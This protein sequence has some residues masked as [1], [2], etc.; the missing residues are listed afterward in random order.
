MLQRLSVGLAVAFLLAA[1]AFG[2]VLAIEAPLQPEPIGGMTKI[3][4]METTC[5]I[6]LPGEQIPN[7]VRFNINQVQVL[8]YQQSANQ[9]YSKSAGGNINLA[10]KTGDFVS[11]LQSGGANAEILIETGSTPLPLTEDTWVPAEISGS[12]S[13][14]GFSCDFRFTTVAHLKPGFDVDNLAV[15]ISFGDRAGVGKEPGLLTNVVSSDPYV[16]KSVYRV[17]AD[18]SSVAVASYANYATLTSTTTMYHMNIKKYE[19]YEAIE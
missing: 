4:T 3:G 1:M 13:M 16:A 12:F 2:I 18:Q 17:R 11:A 5:I 19:V 9:V 15:D 14:S 10:S 6:N 8:N 7:H